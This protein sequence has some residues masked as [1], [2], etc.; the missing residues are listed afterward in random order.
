MFPFFVSVQ[1]I[2][3]LSLWLDEL[4]SGTQVTYPPPSTP[5]YKYYK[6]VLNCTCIYR[7]NFG[8]V[9]TENGVGA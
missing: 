5:P 1:L 2:V 9:I 6:H 3:R 7:L 4:S 8:D